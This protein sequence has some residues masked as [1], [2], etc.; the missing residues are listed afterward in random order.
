M[1]DYIV[2]AE[3]SE[4]FAKKLQQIALKTHQVLGLRDLSRVDIKVDEKGN[5]FVLEAN[6]I[7]GFTEFSLLPKAAKADGL[8]FDELCCELV[9]YALKRNSGVE[10][11]GKKIKAK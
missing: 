3:I 6:S 10:Q 1:T 8:S 4:A 7:P 5:P 9:S 11:H 2:P